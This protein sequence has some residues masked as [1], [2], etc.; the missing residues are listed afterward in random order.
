MTEN[1]HEIVDIN[2]KE[3][4]LKDP[5]NRRIFEAECLGGNMIEFVCKKMQ[6]HDMSYADMAQKARMSE[7]RLVQIL[8]EPTET[9]VM[10]VYD[11]LNA[12]DYRVDFKFK[13]KNKE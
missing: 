2:L 1:E 9:T 13:T 11:L 4:I 8:N 10:E 6:Q 3:K 12:F 5:E 7:E